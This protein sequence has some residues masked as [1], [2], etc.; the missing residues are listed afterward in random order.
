MKILVLTSSFPR[1]R[2]SHEVRWIHELTQSLSGYG[3]FSLV[4]APHFPCGKI[5]ESWDSVQIIRFV[6]FFPFRFERLA[7]GQGLLFNVR[8]DFLAA[9]GVLPFLISCFLNSLLLYIREPIAVIHTHWLIPQGF[10]GAVFHKMWKIPHVAT[11]HGSDLNIITNHKILAP[12]GRFIIRHS[13]VVTVNSTYMKQ[14]MISFAPD[15]RLNIRVVP[16]GIDLEKY[17]ERSFSD[18]KEKYKASHFILSVGRLIDWKGTIF[19]IDAMSE[20]I[21]SFPNAVLLVAGSG[22]EK[23]SLVRRVHELELDKNVKFLGI[24]N[25]EALC[26]LYQSADI[27]VLPSIQKDG[28]TEALGVVLLE[29][30]A[31]GC[32]VIGSNVGGIPDIITDGESGFLV[33][34]QNPAMLSEKIVVLLSDSLLS[35]KFRKA[36]YETVQQ[37]FSWDVVSLQFSEVY[38]QVLGTHS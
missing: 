19:L 20:V 30:M 27:F 6:Y 7:Y 21:R 4:L 37:R 15:C 36:G 28:K 8:K 33:P 17:R 11:V 23:K 9:V 26:S 5:K 2:D 34:E 12:V 24:V 31:A 35:E 18:F 38:N 25:N 29:A 22:P 10:I 3:F 14:Q 1:T 13:N 16:M 32:P